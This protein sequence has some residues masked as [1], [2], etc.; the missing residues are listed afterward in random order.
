MCT[1]TNYNYFQ[2]LE[3]RFYF[4]YDQLLNQYHS[5]QKKLK[6]LKIR[7]TDLKSG[8]RRHVHM[9][10]KRSLELKSW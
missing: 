7:R 6:C 9:T 3:N 1:L 5:L 4:I 10:S 8:V 2:A